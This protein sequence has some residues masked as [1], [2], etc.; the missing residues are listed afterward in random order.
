LQEIQAIATKNGYCVN[1][2]KYFRNKQMFSLYFK[3]IHPYNAMNYND[4]LVISKKGQYASDWFLK[5]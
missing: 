2:H 4:G 5:Q 1:V 3:V